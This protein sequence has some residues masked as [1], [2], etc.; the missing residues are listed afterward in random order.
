MRPLFRIA[1]PAP[2]TSAAFISRDTVW[3]ISDVEIVLPSS[4][5]TCALHAPLTVPHSTA[6]SIQVRTSLTHFSYQ[7]V[8]SRMFFDS[9]FIGA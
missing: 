8:L 9:I 5:L 2:V 7:K 1:M 4:R 3:S 6:A